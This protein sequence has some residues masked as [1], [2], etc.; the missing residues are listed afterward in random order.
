MRNLSRQRSAAAPSPQN[1]SGRARAKALTQDEFDALPPEKRQELYD[2]RRQRPWQHLTS[3]GVLA[4]V[5]FTAGGLFYTAQT[6][7]T[8]QKTLDSQIQGQV[9]DR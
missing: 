3:L 4:S 7:Q 9:T 1:T 5:V 8:G 2:A 6:W